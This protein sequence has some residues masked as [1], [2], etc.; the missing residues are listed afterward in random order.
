MHEKENE[1]INIK[2]DNDNVVA[3]SKDFSR[4]VNEDKL[5]DKKIDFK[6]LKEKLNKN[7]YDDERLTA[8]VIN[9]IRVSVNC[10]VEIL[11]ET[12]NKNKIINKSTGTAKSVN[13][14][15][16]LISRAEKGEKTLQILHNHTSG[17]PLPH[18]EDILNMIKYKIINSGISG[19][20]GFLNIKNSFKRLN[21]TDIIDIKIGC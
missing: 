10:S 7:V 3:Q 6:D 17:T 20:Y 2:N 9:H 18:P 14:S 13:L 16:F 12:G 11:W 19:N 8:N 21:K 5:N 15:I 1:D 4:D